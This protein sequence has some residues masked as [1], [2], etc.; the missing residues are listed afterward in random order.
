[1]DGKLLVNSQHNNDAVG[2]E[3]RSEGGKVYRM[4]WCCCRGNL[5]MPAVIWNAVALWYKMLWHCCCGK[6]KA[7]GMRSCGIA[8]VV[9]HCCGIAAVVGTVRYGWCVDSP[10]LRWQQ[11][12]ACV[13]C[14]YMAVLCDV[15]CMSVWLDWCSVLPS[16]WHWHCVPRTSCQALTTFAH[17]RLCKYDNFIPSTPIKVNKSAKLSSLYI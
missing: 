3:F 14:C 11:W 13:V 10:W 12:S 17:V 9:R 2:Q 5:V 1:M 6:D 4:L 7:C 16:H 8:A 15:V